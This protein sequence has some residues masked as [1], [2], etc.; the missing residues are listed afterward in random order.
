MVA[1]GSGDHATCSSV[2]ILGRPASVGA[3]EYASFRHGSVSS[4]GVRS[5]RRSP[6]TGQ[7]GPHQSLG[8]LRAARGPWLSCGGGGGLRS[9]TQGDLARLPDRRRLPR[10]HK[11]QGFKRS[12]DRGGV[13]G[14][15]R[16]R[17]IEGREFPPR[18][19]LVG[20]LPAKKCVEDVSEEQARSIARGAQE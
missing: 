5:E 9:R 13:H 14:R 6:N 3:L 12:E 16:R 7:H 17:G 1:H 4:C 8:R 15:C 20:L 10:R 11:C 2:P 18:S 19:L